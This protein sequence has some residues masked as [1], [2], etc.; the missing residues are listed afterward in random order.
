MSD[1]GV[2]Q[3][4]RKGMSKTSDALTE[5]LATAVLG[6]KELDDDLITEIEDRLVMADVG[7]E[8][9]NKIISDLVARVSRTQL[10]DIEVLYDA[11]QESIAEILIPCNKPLIMSR[12]RPFA[13]LVV[14]VNG[15]GK[16]TTIGK[17]AQRLVEYRQSVILAAGDTFRA[18]AVEQLQEWG[19]RIDVPVIAQ[20]SGADSA[21]VVFDAYQS[22]KARDVQVLIADTAGRLHTQQNLMEE[23]Q[24][25]KRALQ[26]IEP[27][28]PHETL[29]VLEG[30]TG[31]NAITQAVE[32]HQALG[33]TGLAITKLDG[34]AKGGIV[35]AI[36]DKLQLP[37]RYIGVGEAVEDLRVFN[38]H[39]YA[40]ALLGR[41]PIT[42]EIT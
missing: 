10:T 22:A 41:E 24:K 26:K 40:G 18:A 17:I 33:V 30:G 29:L 7:I 21:A 19:K 3:R 31:Q 5:G 14:G 4:L 23:L 16:T 15:A 34:S 39:Q 35:L 12:A 36:A 11:L 28:A 2:F 9:T 38:A 42:A 37:I 27:E 1:T 8:T 6:K 13:I 20:K 25:I 32:F